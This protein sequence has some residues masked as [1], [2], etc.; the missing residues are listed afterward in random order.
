MTIN[1]IIAIIKAIMNINKK[2][3]KNMLMINNAGNKIAIKIFVCNFNNGLL[4]NLTPPNLRN[5]ITAI[6]IKIPIMI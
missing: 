2:K 1:K 3:P 4:L 6:V 5:I